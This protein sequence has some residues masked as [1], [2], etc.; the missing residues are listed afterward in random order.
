MAG[1]QIASRILYPLLGPR[2]HIT[3]GL[4]CTGASIG[5]LSLIGFQTSLWWARLLMFVVGLS[6][7]Q[8]FVPTQTTAFAAIS[9]AATGQASTMFNAMRQ[10]G[11][12]L[13]VAVLTTTIVLIG[14]TRISSGHVVANLAAYQITFVV[15]GCFC[16]AATAWSLVIRDADAAGTIPVRRSRRAA[17]PGPLGAPEKAA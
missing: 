11:G 1:A 6:V 7:A 4:V 3:L 5:L 12:A 15:A 9:S 14:P 16:L 2:R 13:G 10:L 8:V 17:Q